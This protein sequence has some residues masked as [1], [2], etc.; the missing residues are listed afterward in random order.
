MRFAIADP[1]YLGR[2][3]RWY[4][5]NGCGD[6]YG[7]GQADNHKDAYLWDK[8]E[9]HKQLAKDLLKNYDGFAIALTVHSLSTYLDVLET[10]S[11]NGIRVG[12]WHRPNAAPSGSRITNNWEPVI[13]NIPKERRAYKTAPRSSDFLTANIHKKGFVGS[14]PADWVE[15]VLNVLGVN[16]NDQVVDLFYGSGAVSNVLAATSLP[17]QGGANGF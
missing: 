17:F 12:V 7:K 14:K 4:G 13:F 1:P 16:E 9:T 11:R 15:W 10:D 5:P 8:P 6:G 3:V 2:A